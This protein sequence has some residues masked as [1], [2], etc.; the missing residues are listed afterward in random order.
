MTTLPFF[1]MSIELLEAECMFPY[2]KLARY[3][4]ANYGPMFIM[5]PT[6]TLKRDLRV[7]K[8]MG[9]KA[10]YTNFVYALKLVVY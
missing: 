9:M 1:G 8:L 3:G 4:L 6:N 5:G 10:C 2:V 7:P